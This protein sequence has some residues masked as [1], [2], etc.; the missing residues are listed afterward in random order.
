M[1]IITRMRP[2][3][4]GT[5]A[6]GVLLAG[7]ACTRPNDFQTL[8]PYTPAEGTQV[9]ITPA[10]ADPDLTPV[11]I[12][13]RNLMIVQTTDGENLLAGSVTSPVPASI[14]SIEGQ[15]LDAAGDPTGKVTVDGSMSVTKNKQAFFEEKGFTVEGDSLEPGLLAELT[16][17]FDQGSTTVKM[18]VVDGSKSAYENFPSPAPTSEVEVDNG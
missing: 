13:L 8:H 3:V 15:S 7:S 9:D 18:P 5:V 10:D 16:I 17:T 14:V 2:I 4:V 1:G 11:P 12:K 6:A